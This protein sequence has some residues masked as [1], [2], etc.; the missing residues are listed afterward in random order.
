MADVLNLITNKDR[1][2]FSENYQYKHDF[3]LTKLFTPEKTNNL[4]VAIAKVVE[5]GDMPV[6]A[7]FH[8]YDTEA[9]IG[10]RTNYR[11][12]ELQKLLIKEKINTTERILELLGNS[13]DDEEAIDFIYDD[14]ENLSS[15]VETRAELANAQLLSTGK[16]T[17]NENNFK[18][19]VDYMYN[20]THNIALSEWEK[21]DHDII[22][23]LEKV[24]DKA[25]KV[26]KTITRAVTSSKIVSYMRN[27][28]AI[29]DYFAR[30]LVLPT[31]NN[32]LNWVYEN[33]GIAFEVYD[34]TY[35]D[36]ANATTVHRFFPENKISFFGGQ[37]AI[38]KGLYG[39]TPEELV[40]NDGKMTKGFIA[41]TQ[42]NTPDPVATWT[43]ASA[44]YIPVMAD[45]DGLFIATVSNASD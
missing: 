36:S 14:M 23:D 25:K 3:K 32:V 27:N 39:V 8:A 11:S 45:I 29:K 17:I 12:I 41:V 30:S 44:V 9:K 18:T 40:L 19:V 37:T 16:L 35:K 22:G 33:F 20:S 6:S 34:D 4:K 13:Y 43:K 2:A 26:G 31:A 1:V 21:A 24:M 7:T 5:N 10:D 15:R 28:T 38:G 42:W